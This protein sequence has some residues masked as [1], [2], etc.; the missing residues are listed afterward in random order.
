MT[1]QNNNIISSIDSV[2]PKLLLLLKVKHS[3]Y[4]CDYKLF[5][6]F[7]FS[8]TWTILFSKLILI[9][10]FYR[11]YIIY[12]G[13]YY[14]REVLEIVEFNIWHIPTCTMNIKISIFI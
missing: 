13:T 5:D 4:T 11:A 1:Q 10:I 6:L 3:Q 9:L 2:A 12:I 14:K 8:K 7:S